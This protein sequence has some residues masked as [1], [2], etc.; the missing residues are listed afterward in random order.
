LPKEGCTYLPEGGGTPF[1]VVT[2]VVRDGIKR[3]KKTSFLE[4]PEQA[5]AGWAALK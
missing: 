3:I 5:L 2:K 1:I 4:A